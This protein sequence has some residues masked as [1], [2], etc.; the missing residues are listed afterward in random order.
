M[1]CGVQS[2]RQAS[3]QHTGHARDSSAP[4]GTAPD[5]DPHVAVGA[6]TR[7]AL[8]PASVFAQDADEAQP[9]PD[10][11][12]SV[13]L[14]GTDSQPLP[15]PEGAVRQ[16]TVDTP[17]AS[18][19]HGSGP[20][21]S[22]HASTAAAAAALFTSASGNASLSPAQST[23][24]PASHTSGYTGPSASGRQ[25][26]RRPSQGASGATE[27]EAPGSA[28]GALVEKRSG[29]GRSDDAALMQEMCAAAASPVPAMS[30]LRHGCAGRFAS[31][32][33]HCL[34]VSIPYH[35][36]HRRCV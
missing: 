18:S 26:S 20:R 24:R 31:S 22:A 16:C 27:G 5:V 3:G 10:V 17:G 30:R 15:V 29:A 7:G 33:A 4:G 35:I 19:V 1:L 12:D 14:T 8:I 32:H 36:D 23:Q 9:E 13:R 28:E 34:D 6:H 2:I 11:H 21:L 25:A